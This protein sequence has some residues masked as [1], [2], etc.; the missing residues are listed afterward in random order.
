M[1]FFWGQA[2][3]LFADASELVFTLMLHEFLGG[4]LHWYFLFCVLD[5]VVIAKVFLM[6]VDVWTLGPVPLFFVFAFRVVNLFGEFLPN[7]RFAT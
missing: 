1:Q 7:S 3:I 6:A 5:L 4:E 2:D